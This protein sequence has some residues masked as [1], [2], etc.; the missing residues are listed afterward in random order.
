M[1]NRK[2]CSSLSILFTQ[3]EGCPKIYF[4]IW[5]YFKKGILHCQI[6]KTVT[7][8]KK[9]FL[10]NST[11]WTIFISLW[12][13]NSTEIMSL[14]DS[15]RSFF[16]ILLRRI[17]KI[18]WNN[19]SVSFPRTLHINTL[20][21]LSGRDRII[22]FNCFTSFY[23]L[24]P[25]KC[26]TLLFIIKLFTPSSIFNSKYIFIGIKDTNKNLQDYCIFI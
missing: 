16:W 23:Y 11:E 26:L 12:P 4:L 20:K 5:N 17:C 25:N 1:A 9:S 2:L 19:I 10:Q 24:F 21:K 7:E 14:I 3:K 22:S 13:Q 15:M 18:I 6:Q 8:R